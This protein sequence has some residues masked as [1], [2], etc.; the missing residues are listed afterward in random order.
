MQARLPHLSLGQPRRVG[1]V[2]VLGR[3]V[4][5][6][7]AR[8]GRV[9]ARRGR[10]PGRVGPPPVV[11][12]DEGRRAQDGRPRAHGG[13]GLVLHGVVR[14]PGVAAPVVEREPLLELALEFFLPGNGG[15]GWSTPLYNAP[16]RQDRRCHPAR[17]SK[18]K[19]G[20]TEKPTALPL[21]RLIKV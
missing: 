15:K 2:Q 10:G 12:A 4:D 16:R 11:A 21:F 9:A 7:L 13:Q 6:V 19:L 20:P 18:E 1:P 14:P 8:R 17:V 3:P 5:A